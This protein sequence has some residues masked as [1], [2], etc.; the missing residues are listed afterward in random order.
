MKNASVSLQ[1]AVKIK[2]FKDFKDFYQLIPFYQSFEKMKN[3]YIAAA[4]YYVANARKLSR[5]H[6]QF[7]FDLASI[8]FH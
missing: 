6:Q 4:R 1:K 5:G 8:L 7:Y 2:D 3:S